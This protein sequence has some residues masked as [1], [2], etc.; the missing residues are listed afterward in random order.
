MKSKMNTFNGSQSKGARQ[1]IEI[2][3]GAPRKWRHQNLQ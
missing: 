2:A 3:I 1:V